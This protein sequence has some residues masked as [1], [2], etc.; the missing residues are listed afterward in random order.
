MD[1]NFPQCTFLAF[2]YIALSASSLLFFVVLVIE[3]PP[4]I[5]EPGMRLVGCSTREGLPETP[6]GAL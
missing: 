6:N 4:I 3:D 5:I 1:P 2:H